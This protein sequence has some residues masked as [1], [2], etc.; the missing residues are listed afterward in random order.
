MKKALILLTLILIIVPTLGK[1][2]YSFLK[3][4]KHGKVVKIQVKGK[5]WTYYKLDRKNPLE[6]V[7]DGPVKVRFITRLDME[8]YKTGDK[9]DYTIYA[10]IDGE[11]THFTRSAKISKGIQFGD[12][13]SGKIGIG[14]DI[15]H[16]FPAGKHKIKLYLGKKDE[17]VVY[18]RVLKEDSKIGEGSQRVAYNPCEFTNIVKILVKEKIYDYY[19]VGPEDSLNLKVIGPATVKVLSRLEYDIT[20]NGDKK[21]RVQVYEDDALKNTFL[22]NTVLSDVAIYAEP[23]ADKSLSQG[24]QF[25]IEVPAGEHCYTFKILDSGRSILLK[26]Y[27]PESALDNTP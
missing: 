19:R 25:F 14:E 13:G 17:K 18:V 1:S 16:E 15:Y 2:K 21:Y 3:P 5:D 23:Y 26:F 9:I 27:I 12:T 11:K 4:D 6:I 7:I 20:M 24:D 22:L 8:E 10:D